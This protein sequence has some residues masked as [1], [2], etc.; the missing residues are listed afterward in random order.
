MLHHGDQAPDPSNLIHAPRDQDPTP[1]IPADPARG[2]VVKIIKPDNTDQIPLH[3]PG[4]SLVV[5]IVRF[6][7]FLG[8]AITVLLLAWTKS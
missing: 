3:A 2:L 1:A 8:L 4:Q 7:I 6:A 5:I